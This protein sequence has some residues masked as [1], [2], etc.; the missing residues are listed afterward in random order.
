[1]CVAFFR[2]TSCGLHAFQESSSNDAT[3]EHETVEDATIAGVFISRWQALVT[4]IPQLCFLT[5][6][7][8]ADSGS[9]FADV[10]DEQVCECLCSLR[11]G[12]PPGL[13]L[14]ACRASGFQRFK[15]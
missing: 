15:D 6:M 12:D 7:V 10:Y 2:Q 8:H 1:M 5:L 4:R 3:G 9:P 14:N 11:W 13:R